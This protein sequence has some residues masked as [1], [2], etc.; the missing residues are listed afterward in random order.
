MDFY[1]TKKVRD[2]CPKLVAAD[3]EAPTE[4]LFNWYVSWVPFATRSVAGDTIVAVN[5]ATR[6]IVAIPGVCKTGVHKALLKLPNR[7]IE[8]LKKFQVREEICEAFR[9]NFETV[10]YHPNHNRIMT[11]RLNRQAED[12]AESWYSYTDPDTYIP[13]DFDLEVN[14]FVYRDKEKKRNFFSPQDLMEDC[15]STYFKMPVYNY[16]AYELLVTLDLNLYKVWRRI[17]VPVDLS[18]AGFSYVME[19]TFSNTI[20]GIHL[21][22]YILRKVDENG[23]EAYKAAFYYGNP[24]LYMDSPMKN[25]AP[26]AEHTISDLFRPHMNVYYNYDFGDDWMFRIELVKT[27]PHCDIYSPKVKDGKGQEP[28]EDVGGVEG[29]KKFLEALRDPQNPE[30]VLANKWANG[31]RWHFSVDPLIFRWMVYPKERYAK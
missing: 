28:P 23:R 1:L 9:K 4:P 30:Y 25:W 5:E 21:H 16:P 12:A 8:V 22:Q 6:L 7:I 10:S 13:W 19:K 31:R 20:S 11:A 27:L 17:I 15:F 2:A 3:P 29:Y 24:E 18:L 14:D 26:E